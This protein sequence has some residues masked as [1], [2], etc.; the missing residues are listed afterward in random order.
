[1]GSIR[2]DLMVDDDVLAYLVMTS[3]M[4]AEILRVSTDLA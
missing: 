3:L 1:M 2:F 4:P